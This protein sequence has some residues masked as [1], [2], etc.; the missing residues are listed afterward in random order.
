VVKA[1]AEKLHVLH[2]NQDAYQQEVALSLRRFQESFLW[3]V[4][5]EAMKAC[6]EKVI[7]PVTNMHTNPAFRL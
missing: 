5:G 3:S 7:L 6:Y 1:F 2:S 4:R